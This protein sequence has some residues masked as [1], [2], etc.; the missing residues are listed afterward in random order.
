MNKYVCFISPRFEINIITHCIQIFCSLVEQKQNDISW[1]S[2]PSLISQGLNRKV[3]QSWNTFEINGKR[4]SEGNKHLWSAFL[5]K[6]PNRWFFL[7][8]VFFKKRKENPSSYWSKSFS[9]TRDFTEEKKK[10]NDWSI[11]REMFDNLRS[12]PSHFERKDFL[13]SLAPIFA[14]L[15]NIW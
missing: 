1:T 10:T 6:Y 7:N 14:A 3:F 13:L 9:N 8:G 4:I 11:P 2:S 15:M 5:M 12:H